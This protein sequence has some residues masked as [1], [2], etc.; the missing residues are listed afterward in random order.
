MHKGNDISGY[1]QFMTIQ[2]I[3]LCIYLQVYPLAHLVLTVLS[4]MI[5]EHAIMKS[6]WAKNTSNP[7]IIQVLNKQLNKLS[8]QQ[9][10]LEK[11]TKAKGKILTKTVVNINN[12]LPYFSSVM[13]ENS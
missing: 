6:N 4:A 9:A 1:I 10:H 13:Q 8:C 12:Q 7:T 11:N 5:W 3:Y 2:I